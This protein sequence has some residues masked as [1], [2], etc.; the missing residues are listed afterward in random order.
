MPLVTCNWPIRGTPR[1]FLTCWILRKL[2]K[3]MK[4]TAVFSE[5]SELHRRAQRGAVQHL[6]A[7]LCVKRKTSDMTDLT[8]T[9]LGK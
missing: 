7:H 9:K 8:L 5:F 4:L 2:E 6:F 3:M 1:Y